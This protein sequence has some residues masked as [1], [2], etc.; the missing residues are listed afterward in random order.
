ML[1]A[2]SCL[3]VCD[4]MDHSPPGSSVHGISQAKILEWVAISFSRGS[5]W[6]RIEPASPALA[7]RFFTSN[8]TWFEQTPGDGEGQ[9]KPGVQQYMGLQRPGHGWAT[10]PQK[11]VN[12]YKQLCSVRT[13]PALSPYILHSI[14][15]L[16]KILTCHDLKIT[17][18]WAINTVLRYYILWELVTL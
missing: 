5:F 11:Y 9:G 15:T 10:K 16:L 3:T 17:R 18:M 13:K 4:P 14:F 6:P 7:G 1:V 2:Q 12:T 8:A